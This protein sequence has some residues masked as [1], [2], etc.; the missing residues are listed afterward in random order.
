MNSSTTASFT[1]TMTEL[2]RADSLMPM[3]RSTVT[4]R[5]DQHRRA[6]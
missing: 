3:T 2:K 4:K 5:D 1:A 6:G